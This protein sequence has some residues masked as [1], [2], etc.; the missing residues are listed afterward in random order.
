MS[1]MQ[2]VEIVERFNDS[3][4]K[5]VSRCRQLSILHGNTNWNV[6]ADSL[7]KHRTDGLQFARAKSRSDSEIEAD[8]EKHKILNM[9]TKH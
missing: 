7:D 3:L 1:E 9:P 6:I 2:R 4:K 5:A 8:I